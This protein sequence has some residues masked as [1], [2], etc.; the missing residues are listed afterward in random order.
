MNSAQSR[1][2]R[3]GKP[4]H[5]IMSLMLVGMLS[6][7]L[8]GMGAGNRDAGDT[9][10]KKI[11]PAEARI[12]M[13]SAEPFVL[14]DVRT[15]EE[16]RERH[17]PGAILIPYTELKERAAAELP[18]KEA[19]ILLYCRSGRRSA[20]AAKELLRQGYTRVYDFGGINDWPYAVVTGADAAPGQPQGLMR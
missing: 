20:I 16:M 5:G 19:L 14:L 12:M 18:D 7:L 15:E 10:Y 17:I 6:F 13:E 4:I 11:T 3:E 9:L 1:R 2:C 8:L